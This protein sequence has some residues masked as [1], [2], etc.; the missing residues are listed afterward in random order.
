MAWITAAETGKRDERG[1]RLKAF[2]VEWYEI[3]RD[4]DGQPI[5]AY[6]NRPDGPPKRLRR[7][8]TYPTSEAAQ[9]RVN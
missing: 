8:E 2:R 3:A 9:D 7:R 1:R 4:A 6:P 5:P